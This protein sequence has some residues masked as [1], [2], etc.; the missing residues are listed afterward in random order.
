MHQENG[1]WV[2]QLSKNCNLYVWPITCLLKSSHCYKAIGSQKHYEKR[3][4]QYLNL[5]L[6]VENQHCFIGQEYL[7]TFL[8][9]EKALTFLWDSYHSNNMPFL[10]WY[11][12]SWFP[13]MKVSQTLVVKIESYRWCSSPMIIMID[14]NNFHLSAPR[15]NGFHY[16]LLTHNV[17][18]G[19]HKN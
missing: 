14:L 5:T 4:W 6:D 7:W 10:L 2:R 9:C 1:Y 19:A 8:T 12:Y 16:W 13:F 15:K 3:E 11:S 17:T 18:C